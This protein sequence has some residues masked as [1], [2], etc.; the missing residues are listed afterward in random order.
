MMTIT[1]LPKQTED[2]IQHLVE[3]G[4]FENESEVVVQ[5]VCDFVDRK[6]R[7]EHLRKLLQVGIDAAD[8]GELVDFTPG[9]MVQIREDARKLAASGAPLDPDVC[10]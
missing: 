8:C 1:Q 10:G 7:T 3:S 5:A 4:D 2:D 6:S 9:L